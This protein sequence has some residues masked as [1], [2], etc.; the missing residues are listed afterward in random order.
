MIVK[1]LTTPNHSILITFGTHR[2]GE[3]ALPRLA[4][5]ITPLFRMCSALGCPGTFLGSE[6]KR[7]LL[8][9]GKLHPTPARPH[10]AAGNHAGSSEQVT[11]A[12]QV[13]Q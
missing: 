13:Q 5:F 7:F 8:P 4:A 3:P 11:E 1:V 2:P 10:R 6:V 9:R 12:S